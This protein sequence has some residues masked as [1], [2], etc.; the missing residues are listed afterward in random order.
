MPFA[1]K[2]LDPI[3]GFIHFDD[4]ERQVIDSRAF[5]R[6][7]YLRQLGISYLVYPG[8][9]HTRFEHS[10][11]V[12]ELVTRIYDTITQ[13]SS[14]SKEELHY[15][16]RI[17]RI[18]AL[19]HDMGHLPFS[20]T[21]EKPL[22]P[23]GGH[24]ERT[25]A[26]IQSAPM[27]A[28]WREIG[29]TAEEDIIKIALSKKDFSSLT[30]WEKVLSKTIT[31][32]NFGADRVDYLIRDA[33]YTGVGY[34]HFDYRHLI[35]SLRMLPDTI[36]VA[37]DGMLSVESLWIARYMMYARVY[38]HP[39]C[40][41]YSWHLTRFM[42]RHY[43]ENGFPATIEG[44]LSQTDDT[45]L[46]ALSEAARQGDCDARVLLK[47]SAPYREVPLDM[48]DEEAL[49]E[50]LETLGDD[51]F[52][53]HLPQKGGARE[54]T[55]V[56]SDGTLR[57]SKEVSAFLREIPLVGRQLRIF[58]PEARTGEVKAWL[59]ARLESPSYSSPQG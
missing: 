40:R 25:L 56:A 15:W 39:K 52:I 12:M 58:A 37:S 48:F 54:F 55:V 10:L 59:Q 33:V 34:G 18:A 2:I 46:Q 47:Q 28:L 26:V 3:H 36:G 53:D 7:R 29:P 14:L 16:R 42:T 22:L 43:C 20:H 24:E 50:H 51:L 17:L 30:P 41:L 44:Y 32:D 1:Y 21:A 38:F 19:C 49:V 6:L 5:Q 45:I 11:G 35:E 13:E 23:V 4:V 9:T 31:E 27:R 8:A 57:P